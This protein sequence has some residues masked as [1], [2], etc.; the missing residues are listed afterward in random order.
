MDDAD[1]VNRFHPAEHIERKNQGCRDWKVPMG[2][3]EVLHRLPLQ[4]FHDD[5]G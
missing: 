3:K 5:E 4:K 1:A 2:Q